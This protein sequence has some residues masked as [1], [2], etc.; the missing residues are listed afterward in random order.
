VAYR[1]GKAKYTY[2]LKSDPTAFEKENR[3]YDVGMHDFK[4]VI[5]IIVCTLSEHLVNFVL[6]VSK[7]IKNEVLNTSVIVVRLC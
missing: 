5:I 4:I 7:E 2:A 6:N 1:L 3:K